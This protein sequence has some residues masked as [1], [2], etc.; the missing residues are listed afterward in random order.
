VII[1]TIQAF[2]E[3]GQIGQAVNSLFEAGVH[4]VF[5]LDGA[6][7]NPD[8]TWFGGAGHKSSDRTVDEAREAGAR[9]D[10]VPENFSG[11]DGA[12]RDLLVQYAGAAL[13][14]H[15]LLLDAD[16]LLVGRVS[17]PAAPSEHGCIVLHNRE[18]DLPGVRTP[19]LDKAVRESVPLLRWFRFYPTLRCRA[20]GQYTVEGKLL[21][22]YLTQQLQ[23]ELAKRG[24][25]T[26]LRAAYTALRD[27]EDQLPNEYLSAY[28]IVPGVEIVHRS[29]PR[30][31]RIQAKV[32]YYGVQP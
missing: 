9:V 18:N 7:R 26:A 32:R 3:E 27:V 10:C 12:K 8:G 30:A 21:R 5:V 31:A 25:D 28:P 29:E 11:G 2:N 14:D 15:L 1:G 4:K 19:W 16:E 24:D 13:G 22:P 17:G 20:P 23:D 6:W